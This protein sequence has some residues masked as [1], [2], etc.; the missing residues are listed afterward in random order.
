[1]SLPLITNL[2]YR[3]SFTGA[4]SHFQSLSSPTA[5]DVAFAIRSHLSLSPPSL[6]TARSL[7]TQ[8]ASLLGSNLSKGFQ[9]FCDVIEQVQT[10]SEDLDL[11]IQ[12]SALSDINDSVSE[13]GD[14]NFDGEKEQIEV[15][16]ATTQYLDQDPIGALETL[17][18][19]STSQKN[20]GSLALGVHL[21]LL[22]HRVDLAEKEYTAAR[23]WAED[24][25]VI[26][27]IEAALGLYKGGRASQQ[28]Y[29]VYDEFASVGSTS[30]EGSGARS[31][32]MKL[33]RA[34]GLMKR[35][36]YTRAEETVRE[37]STMLK[38]DSEGG[39]SKSSLDKEVDANQAVLALYLN[40]ASKLPNA[41]Q[42]YLK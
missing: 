10:T 36:E 22:I 13:L 15:L 37:A 34:V 8:H 4:I 31:C 35:G 3:S 25:L 19:G 38:Q 20:L 16:L 24:S 29:Y 30:E 18:M 33:G 17:Q 23:V 42:E 32:G 11:G 9:T 40:P 41:G 21:L 12:V 14:V 5:I 26:Q 39:E 2:F 27:L 7:A 1:M 28:A 6:S